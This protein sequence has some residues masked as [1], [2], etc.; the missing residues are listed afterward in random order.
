MWWDR[1]MLTS[2]FLDGF[3]TG[4][5]STRSVLCPSASCLLNSLD[6]AYACGQ[7][8]FETQTHL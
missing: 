7:G 8:G 3:Y 6:I 2:L 4:I 5:R 1:K